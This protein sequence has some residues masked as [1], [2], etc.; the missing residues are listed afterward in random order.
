[1]IIFS[2]AF[3]LAEAAASRPLTHARIG[4][5]TWTRD[6]EPSATTASSE[7]SDGPKDAPLR[8]D[9]AEYWEPTALPAT[10]M[11]DFGTSRDVD[12]VGVAGHTL[13]SAGCAVL[14]ET[15]TND[16]AGSPLAEV[17]TPLGSEIAPGDDSP[18]LF[19]DSSRVARKVRLTITGGA[20]MP[21]VAVVYAGEI[22]AM[23]REVY[24]GQS[25]MN[26]SRDTELDRNLSRGGQFLGQG[27]R[28]HGQAGSG[29]PWRYLTPDWYRANFDPFV[30][31]ARQYP[32]FYA[33]RP[34]DYPL[35]VAYAWVGEDIRPSNM[36][37]RE[38][39]QVGFQMHGVGYE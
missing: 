36:G 3:L 31:A 9:T 6:L 19:L 30:R 38:F 14:V 29:G 4:Y 2:R 16:F 8:P 11:V 21:R 7:A 33:W 12:Y 5:Q 17:W 1:M 32:F 20:I 23:E 35:E 18:L 10:W 26:L 39:M 25:P 34:E 28:R 13:G 37:V 27:F 15:S 22:L 24:G